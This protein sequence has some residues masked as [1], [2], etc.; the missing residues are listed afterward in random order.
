MP[1]YAAERMKR[2][3]IEELALLWKRS[4]ST[5]Y[6]YI[7]KKGLP[8]RKDPKNGTIIFV[9]SD[10]YDWENEQTKKIYKTSLKEGQNNG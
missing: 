3:T 8:Y 10:I 1:H 6:R 9:A 4:K 2:Y 5:I 7:Y